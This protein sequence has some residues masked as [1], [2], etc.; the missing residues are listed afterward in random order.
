MFAPLHNLVT[1]VLDPKKSTTEGGLVLPETF[2]DVFV[3]GVIRAV[4][5]GR[6]LENGEKEQLA[7]FP[8]DRVMFAQ[9]CEQGPGGRRR[10]LPYPV[11]TDEGVE[12]SL[13]NYTDILGV[14]K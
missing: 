10:M 6:A 1:V 8:G 12:C 7:V 4:G 13:L 14:V 9:H 3:T 11:L 5:P 2:Q